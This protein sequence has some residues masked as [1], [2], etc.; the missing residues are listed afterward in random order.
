ML[1]RVGKL[2]VADR[3]YDGNHIVATASRWPWMK[4]VNILVAYA[5]FYNPFSALKALV[6][7]DRFWKF[8]LLYQFLGHL[9]ILKS[10]WSA[11]GWTRRLLTGP[12][13]RL[14]NAPVAEVPPRA[15]S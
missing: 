6:K 14:R 13:E 5:T 7:V 3:H 2:P 11:S 12:V 8:R 4:Q 1:G 15:A 10:A 9:G